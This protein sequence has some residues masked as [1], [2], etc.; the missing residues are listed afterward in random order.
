MAGYRLFAV[1][2]RT[3]CTPLPAVIVPNH[4]QD[5]SPQISSPTVPLTHRVTRS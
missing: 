3:A 1:I 4:Q 2:N 5:P